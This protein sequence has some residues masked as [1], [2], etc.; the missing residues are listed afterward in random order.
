MSPGKSLVPLRGVT[1][2]A[3]RCAMVSVLWQR[4]VDGCDGS[5]RLRN[6]AE[7]LQGR[8]KWR[9]VFVWRVISSWDQD[10]NCKHP[11]D[12]VQHLCWREMGLQSL[13]GVR[14]GVGAGKSSCSLGGQGA[15]FPLCSQPFLGSLESPG[16]PREPWESLQSPGIPREPWGPSRALGSLQGPLFPLTLPGAGGCERHVL[17]FSN[18]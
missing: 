8:R 18:Q 4:L 6:L 13:R 9:K 14:G 15:P 16:V 2:V 17:D 12:S 7:L 11:P 3:W 10:G 5:G 1:H